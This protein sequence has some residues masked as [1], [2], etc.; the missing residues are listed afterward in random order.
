MFEEEHCSGSCTNCR[1]TEGA[2][3]L[4]EPGFSL[5]VLTLSSSDSNKQTNKQINKQRNKQS[6]KETN[7][8]EE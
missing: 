2:S 1:G 3:P 4:T 6:N 7:N 8:S 5:Q